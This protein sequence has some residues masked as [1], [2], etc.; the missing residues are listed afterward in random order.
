MIKTFAEILFST[1]KKGITLIAILFAVCVEYSKALQSEDFYSKR[2][3]QLD[4]SV[5]LKKKKR[6]PVDA[7]STGCSCKMLKM[8]HVSIRNFLLNPPTLTGSCDSQAN[9]ALQ[10][11][12]V[13]A[14][15]LQHGIGRRKVSSAS[16]LA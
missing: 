11:K 15:V 10:M 8:R 12:P 14:S 13:K 9:D 1:V 4:V 2:S 3:K 5:L 6:F 7:H 16:A